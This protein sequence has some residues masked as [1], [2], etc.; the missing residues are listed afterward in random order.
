M[1]CHLCKYPVQ[2]A[3]RRSNWKAVHNIIIDQGL[4]KYSNQLPLESYNVL[5]ITVEK[6]W[7]LGG[8]RV[9]LLMSENFD[10]CTEGHKKIQPFRWAN[11]GKLNLYI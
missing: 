2:S 10:Q 6:G 4:F 9:V 7:M 8:Q 3:D 5:S 11:L 1:H